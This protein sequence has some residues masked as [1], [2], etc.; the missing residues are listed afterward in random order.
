MHYATV[1]SQECLLLL[2]VRQLLLAV[3][4]AVGPVRASFTLVDD[5]TEYIARDGGNVVSVTVLGCVRLE[6]ENPGYAC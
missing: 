6:T 2:G 3:A 1:S 4:V 5:W